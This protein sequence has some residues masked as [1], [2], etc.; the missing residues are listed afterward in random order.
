MFF[1]NYITSYINIT[2]YIINKIN[3]YINIL[4]LLPNFPA[5]IT[6]N[7]LQTTIAKQAMKNPYKIRVLSRGLSQIIY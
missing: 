4:I 7:A 2:S 5:K 1:K 6:L 3:M